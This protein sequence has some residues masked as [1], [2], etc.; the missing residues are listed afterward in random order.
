M[1]DMTVAASGM[2]DAVRIELDAAAWD[3]TEAAFLTAPDGRV[4]RRRGTR[5]SRRTAAERIADGAPLVL[6]YWAGRQLTW[7][8]HDEA[9]TEW[10]RVRRRVVHTPTGQG[11][12]EWTAGTWED[13]TGRQLVFLEGHC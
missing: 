13:D 9:R 5:S 8:D 1:S 2:L 12:V 11:A 4:Y 3:E 7:C 10:T 6:R